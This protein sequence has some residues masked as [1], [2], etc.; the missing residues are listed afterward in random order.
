MTSDTCIDSDKAEKPRAKEPDYFGGCPE[1]LG[2]DGHM[3][4]RSNHWCVCDKHKTKWCAGANLFSDWQE[5]SDQIWED[6]TRVLDG[7][8]KVE[9]VMQV[10]RTR[11]KGAYEFASKA[12]LECL[13]GVA[14]HLKD[15]LGLDASI[16]EP[17]DIC[18]LRV[19]DM[20]WAFSMVDEDLGHPVKVDYKRPA[21]RR[22]SC[23]RAE[24]DELLS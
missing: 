19:N 21:P 23:G 4:V 11:D 13:F 2:N 22:P 17:N 20:K 24:Q 14:S 1:C 3:N 5:E 18:F 16:S 8:R 10:R 6:N 7:S 9:P 15:D 12:V